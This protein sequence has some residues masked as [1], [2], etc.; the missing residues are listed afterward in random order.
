MA[1][2][3]RSDDCESD[4]CAILTEWTRAGNLQGN[5]PIGMGGVCRLLVNYSV[6]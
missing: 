6:A 3:T 1:V 5:E 2:A 4:D